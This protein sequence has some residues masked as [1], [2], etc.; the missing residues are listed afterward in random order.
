MWQYVI[1]KSLHIVSVVLFLGNIIT[2]V[3]WKRHGDRI[4]TPVARAQALAGVIASDRLFTVPG[5]V[6]IIV[7]GVLLAMSL[8]LPLLRT[9]WIAWALGLFG[10]SGILFSMRVAPLQKKLLAIA[11]AGVSG[12]WDE[13]A[14]RK[15]SLSWEIWGAIATLLPL[16]VV[17][18]MVLKPT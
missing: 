18:L 4:G 9:L 14:Y 5:V 8:D 1:L 3:F 16:I 11:Q 7:T 13:A 2:G 15:L 10:L 17:V 12:H 6:A